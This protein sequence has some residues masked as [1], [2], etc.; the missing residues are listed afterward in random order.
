MPTPARFPAAVVAF[1][2]T[3]APLPAQTVTGPEWELLAIDGV[4]VDIAVNATLR[5]EPDGRI[6]GRAPCNQWSAISLAKLPALELQA[7]RA[8][9][10]ACDRLAEEQAF[11][12]ALGAMTALEIEERN[13]ILTG[14]EGRSMEFVTTRMNSLTRCLTCPP[15]G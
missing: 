13:L 5:I 1:C 6:S 12:D 3:I 14:P 10:M 8:T 2:L 4:A 9:R 7:I 11:F 15:K